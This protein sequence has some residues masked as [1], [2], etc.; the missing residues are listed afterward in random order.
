MKTHTKGLRNLK[1][2]LTKDTADFIQSWNPK[3]TGLRRKLEKKSRIHPKKNIEEHTE[4]SDGNDPGPS[5]TRPISEGSAAC[6]GDT[7][8]VELE[9]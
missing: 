6:L 2:E 4:T 7:I 5:Y 9:E 8:P 3:R 1:T